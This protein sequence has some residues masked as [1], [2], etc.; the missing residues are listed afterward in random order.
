L[1]DG[2]FDRVP[3]A[4]SGQLLRRPARPSQLARDQTPGTLPGPSPAF[5]SRL[6]V[7]LICRSVFPES[8][9]EILSAQTPSRP[10]HG[11]VA[12]FGRLPL[13]LQTA[14]EFPPTSPP[15]LPPRT[16]YPSSR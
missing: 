10:H 6:Y 3:L 11:Q 12:D 7:A 4:L 9:R 5:P 8:A 1:G 15:P 2:H 13:I 16:P 14:S